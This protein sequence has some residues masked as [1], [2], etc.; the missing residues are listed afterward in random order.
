MVEEAER[1]LVMI[2]SLIIYIAFII[3]LVILFTDHN[4]M[5]DFGIKIYMFEGYFL[6]WWG[7][8]ITGIIDVIGA[9]IL[10]LYHTKKL[11][12][13]GII[14]TSLLALFQV[15]DIFTYSMLKAGLTASQFAT[16]L[17]GFSKYP[18]TEPYIP[19]MYDILLIVYIIASIT[20]VFVLS[21]S[22]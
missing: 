9:S 13:V 10:L 14:G 3:T 16:Y 18:S 1:K 12:K 15:L 20:G 8:L 19:G 4:L 11:V 5:N 6:H 2:Q 21:K 22:K 7:L 17:F